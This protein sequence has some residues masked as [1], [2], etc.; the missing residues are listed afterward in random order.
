MTSSKVDPGRRTDYSGA[1][2]VLASVAA[3]LSSLAFF[4]VWGLFSMSLTG[5]G[6]MAISGAGLARE[7]RGPIPWLYITPVAIVSVLVV[8]A[9]RLLKPGPRTRLAYSLF[10]PLTAAMLLLWPV[11]ALAKIT[12]HFSRLQVLGEGTMR[13]SSWWWI[14]C[15]SLVMVMAFGII[16]LGSMIRKYLKAPSKGGVSAP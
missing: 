15:S 13:L 2:P 14:Y 9:M 5:T 11:D 10:L 6:E 1:G 12:R 8:S 7:V 4:R 16:E 3:A